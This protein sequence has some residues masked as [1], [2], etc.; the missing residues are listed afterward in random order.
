[1]VANSGEET[2]PTIAP[3][4]PSSVFQRNGVSSDARSILCRY[5][6]RRSAG[7]LGLYQGLRQAVGENAH[8]LHHCRNHIAGFVYLPG[9]RLA[10]TGEVLSAQAKVRCARMVFE[11]IR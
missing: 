3:G 11:R 5:R 6:L 4:W 8:G 7:V 2:G 10:P 9:V 1:M